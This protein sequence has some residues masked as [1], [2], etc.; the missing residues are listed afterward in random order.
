MS[1]YLR[2]T[3]A[4]RLKMPKCLGAEEVVFS[5]DEFASGNW[6][7]QFKRHLSSFKMRQ[8]HT[9]LVPC[10]RTIRK[11]QKRQCKRNSAQKLV[12]S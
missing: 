12:N 5:E 1:H 2:P 8:L 3:A 7:G 6:E 10:L 4:T 9:G 11:I